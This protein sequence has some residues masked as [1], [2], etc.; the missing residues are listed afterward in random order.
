MNKTVLIAAVTSAASLV[1][2]GIAGYL[3][4][5]R[6]LEKKYQGLLEEEIE[7]T[8]EFY[9]M[10]NAKL[11]YPTPGDA[12]AA[13]IPEEEK[14]LLEE[15]AG[16]IV[17]RRY[18]LPGAPITQ[19]LEKNVFEKINVMSPDD[20]PQFQEMVRKRSRHMPYVVT[21]QEYL[22]NAAEDTQITMT[23][24]S[25][26]NVLADDKEQ[27]VDNVNKIVGIENLQYFGRWSN[28][29]NIVY[30]RNERL[31]AMFEVL[32]SEGKYA[33]EVL[34]LDPSEVD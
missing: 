4:A 29:E 28:Q 33:I 14:E 2:G 15:V 26:D 5:N 10:I 20:D 12:V 32:R 18:D 1:A 3:L 19:V 30:I 27:T 34:G 25:G 22:E 7:Q 8:K 6:R 17:R 13:L 9:A 31:T 16:A 24:Y 11:S 21:A 23:W